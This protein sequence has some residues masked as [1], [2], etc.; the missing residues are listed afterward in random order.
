MRGYAGAKGGYRVTVLRLFSAVALLAVVAA[1]CG[2]GRTTRGPADRGIP[3]ALAHSW[4]AQAS[5]IA[6]AAASRDDCKAL[7][8]ARSLRSRVVATE[9]RVPVRL[10]SP[11]MTGVNALVSRL[12]CTPPPAPTTPKEPPKPPEPPHDK[13]DDHGHHDHHGKG[14]KDK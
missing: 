12:T 14:G 11:L 5:A 3:R 8:L 4:E 13:H 1:G 6:E 10:R 2:S 7:D 9:R